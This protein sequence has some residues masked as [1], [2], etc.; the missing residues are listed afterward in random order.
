V[1]Q[2]G[3]SMMLSLYAVSPVHAGSGSSFGYVDLPIQ[4]ERHTNWPHIQASGV[5][6]ALRDHFEN[7]YQKEGE[8]AFEIAKIIFGDSK[9]EEGTVAG[10]ISVSDA[11]IL[12]YPMRSNIAPFVWVTAPA[13]LQR[14]CRDLNLCGK[15]VPDLSRLT[16]PNR[17][18]AL[19]LSGIPEN[20]KVLLEDMEVTTGPQQAAMQP[21]IAPFFK[22]VS[23][24]LLV[25]DDVFK[26]CVDQCTDVQAQIMI[27]DETGTTKDGSLR[28]QELLPN[29][30]VMYVVVFW[31]DSK[32]E[33]STYKA[34]TLIGAVK[35]SLANGHIQMG[36]D[37]TLGRGLFSVSII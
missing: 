23:R 17:E 22:E 4:R 7:F 29:D 19:P 15:K 10:A 1:Y 33:A 6:G 25:H 26:Y 20:V 24:L 3:N 13:V 30:T 2:T 37:L 14:L 8:N 11:K 27:N 34:D 35:E 18:M 16:V 21:E 5:K 9:G 36:G 31:G 12:A 28:Y 32:D